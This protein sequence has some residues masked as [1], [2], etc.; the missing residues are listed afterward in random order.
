M[1]SPS[2][3]T[4]GFRIRNYMLFANVY[5]FQSRFYLH[6]LTLWPVKTE[7]S[8]VIEVYTV[9]YRMWVSFQE[10]YLIV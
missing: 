6:F 8:L 5:L 4:C 3:Y 9:C 10:Q 1:K 7:M 2:T